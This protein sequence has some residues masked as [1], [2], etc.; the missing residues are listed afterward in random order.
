M[1]ADFVA[2]LLEGFEGSLKAVL[3]RLEEG[4]L[5]REVQ[6]LRDQIH[7]RRRRIEATETAETDAAGL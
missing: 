3:E 1:T 2:A 5:R 4:D 7:G 6:A